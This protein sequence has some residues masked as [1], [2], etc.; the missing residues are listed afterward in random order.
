[1]TKSEEVEKLQAEVERLKK[2]LKKGKN[3]DNKIQKSIPI[4]F[5]P[6]WW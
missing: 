5:L 4:L 3:M 2:E 1:M 6:Q